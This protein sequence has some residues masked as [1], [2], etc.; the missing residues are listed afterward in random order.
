MCGKLRFSRLR[1]WIGIGPDLERLLRYAP[2]LRDLTLLDLVA[3]RLGQPDV[4]TNEDRSSFDSRGIKDLWSPDGTAV[5]S[6]VD[7]SRLQLE[8]DLTSFIL[9][10]NVRLVR[11]QDVLRRRERAPEDLVSG[12]SGQKGVVARKQSR[13]PLSWQP[14]P[15]SQ[16]LKKVREE[17]PEPRVATGSLRTGATG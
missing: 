14:P 6:Q 15:G 7:R 3:S 12:N 13:R 11:R 1:R 17:R 10:E 9:S 5:L 2:H 16:R 8:G 4:L